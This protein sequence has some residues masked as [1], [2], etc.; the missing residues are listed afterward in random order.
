MSFSHTKCEIL[1]KTCMRN[2]QKSQ[3]EQMSTE[4]Q[5]AFVL[6]VVGSFLLLTVLLVSI[7][8]VPEMRIGAYEENA[9][10]SLD[11]VAPSKMADEPLVPESTFPTRISIEKIA[12]DTTIITPQSTDIDVLDRALLN[13]AVHYPGS[14]NLGE[15]ANMLLFGHS[16]YLP[17]INNKAFKAFNELSKLK[18]GDHITVYSDTHVYTYATETV[19][20]SE[21]EDV[22]VDF[23]SSYPK[24]TLATCNSFGTKQ[25][26]WIVTARLIAKEQR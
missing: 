9:T 13:G 11:V 24:L 10:S 22:R 15:N 7:D 5:K 21:A 17:V 1:K 3:K 12:L 18:A 8:F 26:R 25:E 6:R 14:G 16:S 4:N 20:L 23:N 19:E 2:F